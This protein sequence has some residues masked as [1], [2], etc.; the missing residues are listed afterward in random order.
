MIKLQQKDNCTIALMT[1][2]FHT[3]YS[4]LIANAICNDLARDG[5]RVDIFLFQG[6]DA[7]RYLTFSDAVTESFDRH[8]YSQFEY[9]KYIEPD[10]LI[11]SFG[12]ISAVPSPMQLSEFLA[13]FG[14]VP[15]ILLEDETE[16]ENGI[17]I[18]V[19]NYRGMYDLVSHLIEDHDCKRIL[20]VSGPEDVPDSARRLAAYRDAMRDHGLTVGKNMVGF[21]N[22]TDRVD[23]LVASLLQHTPNA[24]AVCCAND[25]MAES[26]YRVL[27]P[28][29]LYPGTDIAVTG[30]DDTEGARFMNPP[31]TTVR[32]DFGEV[33]TAVVKSV[34]RLLG[35][36]EVSSQTIPA[37][38]IRRG[39]CKC[40]QEVTRTDTR[41]VMESRGK[42]QEYRERIKH[43]RRRN[44]ESSL[45]MRGVLAGDIAW[46]SFFERLGKML[47][48]VGTSR[49]CI[50]LIKNPIRVDGT[51]RYFLP[52][53]LYLALV[54]HGKTITTY[55]PGEAPAA[56][57]DAIAKTVREHVS[58]DRQTAV[59]PVF[60]GEYHYG[61]MFVELNRNDMVFYYA[62]SLEL[63]TGLRYLFMK[64][65][66]DRMLGVKSS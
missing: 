52:D 26:A 2:S 55:G 56:D 18:T 1:G 10:L 17:S 41:S 66:R 16:L 15:V 60:Y 11:L 45:L 23:D 7:S 31:L 5:H 19:D 40:L 29:G 58:Y 65:D 42:A 30:F 32:Q 33:A 35:G 27:P 59:F 14:D 37:R 9:A 8:Y 43:L 36:E 44:I 62:L 51:Q 25:E 38:M 3:D 50:Y 39:S 49:T 34:R 53:V 63:G 57:R 20:Y 13:P 48:E 64:L 61:A 12:T 54:Q 22:F 4:R 6:L 24:E 47:C 28:R 46:K 21:G